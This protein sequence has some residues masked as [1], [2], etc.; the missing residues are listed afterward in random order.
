MLSDKVSLVAVLP[1]L[2]WLM[3]KTSIRLAPY[4]LLLGVVSIGCSSGGSTDESTS[5]TTF[6]FET[7]GDGDGDGDSVGDGDGDGDGEPGDGDGDGEPGDGDGDGEP[8]PL[9]GDGVVEGAEECDDGNPSDGDM[10]TNACANAVCGD[11]IVQEG[12]EACD[13]GND[14]EDDGCT[15]ACAM[16]TCGN[17]EVEPGETCDD[18]NVDE[19]DFC[20][21][22][23]MMATCGDGHVWA[24]NE[25]CDDGN[26]ENTDDCIMG[27]V[28]AACGD[29]YV[30]ANNEDCDEGGVSSQTCDSDCSTVTCGDG[31]V[32]EDAGE[33][34]DDGNDV[35]NDG[36]ANDCTST[37]SCLNNNQWMP[38]NCS[39][40]Q[41]VW[42]SDRINAPSLAQANAMHVLW[43]G[44]SHSGVANTCSLDGT[45]WVSTQVTAM[46]GCNANWYH[47][48]GS[49]TGNC[50]GHDGDQIRRLALGPND[51]YAY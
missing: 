28:P 3:Q 42:S 6:P 16:F 22:A 5:F 33:E 2:E 14:V 12:I 19:T 9:C 23:C 46:A 24:G 48:G 40:M 41:W 26:M 34:C 38:V 18:G 36:C 44:C 49:Y 4:L 50:G 8:G 39:T 17:G 25:A 35:G 32:N 51:C 20:T 11:G 30:W 7:S 37:S 47:L 10:C 1:L 29:N 27:C 21:N 31:F 43:T 13:D 45:G 15:S